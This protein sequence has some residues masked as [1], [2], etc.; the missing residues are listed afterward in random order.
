M[1]KGENPAKRSRRYARELK[2]GRNELT[3]AELSSTAILL[4]LISSI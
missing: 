4:F 1:A 3:G 2:K